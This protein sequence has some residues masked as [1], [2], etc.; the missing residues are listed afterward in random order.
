MKLLTEKSGLTQT[1]I[2]EIC[3]IGTKKGIRKRF[4]QEMLVS[5]GSLLTSLKRIATGDSKKGGLAGEF[6]EVRGESRPI[7]NSPDSQTLTSQHNSRKINHPGNRIKQDYMA[8][9]RDSI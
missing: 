7:N 3:S 6:C 5:Q 2:V 9:G 1:Q 4:A 8:K